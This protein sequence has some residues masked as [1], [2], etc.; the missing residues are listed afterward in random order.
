MTRPTYLTLKVLA[1]AIA[2]ALTACVLALMATQKP[3]GAAFPGENGRIAFV[4]TPNGVGPDAEIYTML[5][6]GSNQRQLTSTTYGARSPAWSADGTK[7]AFTVYEGST[8]IYTMNSDGS[9]LEQLTPTDGLASADPAWSP[10]G[11]KIAF[12]SYHVEANGYYNR[13]IYVMNADGSGVSRLTTDLNLDMAP[14]WSPD[15]TKIAFERQD[16]NKRLSDIWVMN[17]SDGSSQVNLTANSASS[18][19]FSPDWSPDGTKI[20]FVGDY[21]SSP[22]TELYTVDASG[23]PPSALTNT[24]EVQEF[25]PVWSPDGAE[26]MFGAYEF[27][28]FPI[29][30]VTGIWRM[31]ADGT[32]RININPSS[33]VGDTDWQPKLPDTTPPSVTSTVPKADATEVAPTA[34]VRATFSEEMDSNTIDDTTFQLFKRGTTTQIAAQ[35]SYNADTDTAKLDPT[36]NLKRGVAYKAVVSTWAKDVEGNGLDQDDSTSGF[37]QMRWFFRVDD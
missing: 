10:D 5:P 22:N 7:I 26:I 16:A 2:L 18:F 19:E 14:V 31:R 6:D 30:S 35:V 21:G 11:T 37:Q 13:D 29:G 17:A 28:N 33:H 1:I 23:S 36:D 27:P 20:V 3:A 15:G 12:W 34:N 25:D 9:G 32:N 4:G 24:P 8:E